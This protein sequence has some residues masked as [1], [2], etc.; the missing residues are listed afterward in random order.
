MLASNQYPMSSQPKSYVEFK[1]VGYIYLDFS[2]RVVNEIENCSLLLYHCHTN[3]PYN[4]SHKFF[5]NSD[6]RS[7]IVIATSGY[8]KILY[9]NTSCIVAVTMVIKLRILKGNSL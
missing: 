1:T 6:I 9:G 7:F 5:L 2:S 3:H 8:N 4:L